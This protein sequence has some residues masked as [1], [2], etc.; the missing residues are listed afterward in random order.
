MPI[1]AP[2]T[3][4]WGRRSQ[5][6]LVVIAIVLVILA[7][8][9]YLVAVILELRKITAG[10]DAVI[11]PVSEIVSKSKPPKASRPKRCML[12]DKQQC[13]LVLFAV[14]VDSV[15]VNELGSE[16]VH[17]PKKTPSFQTESVICCER[18]KHIRS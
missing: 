9:I 6:S 7:L 2:N 1:A 10:L 12:F 15:R 16:L 3:R 14:H 13:R 5:Q 11:A 4:D 17:S 18:L 8:V